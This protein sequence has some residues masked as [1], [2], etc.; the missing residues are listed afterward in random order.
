M[1]SLLG[2]I[3]FA[4]TK[5]SG[6]TMIRAAAIPTAS[7][8]PVDRIRRAERPE[9]E[10]G[11]STSATGISTGVSVADRTAVE[12]PHLEQAEEQD[13]QDQDVADRRRIPHREVLEALPVDQHDQG[14]GAE[15]GPSL[16]HDV[17]L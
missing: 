17:D 4:N 14:L 3:E 7:A 13:D 2:L 11:A 15:R 12:V 9:R 8:Q 16:S 10:R 6:N 1:I 5:T